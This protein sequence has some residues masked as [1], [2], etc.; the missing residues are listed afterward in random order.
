MIKLES[1]MG[2]GFEW[3]KKVWSELSWISGVERKTHY[4]MAQCGKVQYI[5]A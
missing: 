3:R 2:C 1:G 5:D 4:K